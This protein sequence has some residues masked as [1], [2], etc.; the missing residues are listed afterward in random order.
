MCEARRKQRRFD[1]RQRKK[2]RVDISAFTSEDNRF[3]WNPADHYYDDMSKALISFQNKKFKN[4]EPVIQL[5]SKED[6][7]N[8]TIL[9]IDICDEFLNASSDSDS[10]AEQSTTHTNNFDESPKQATCQYKKSKRLNDL[11]SNEET[12]DTI[13]MSDGDCMELSHTHDDD[14]TVGTND[15]MVSTTKMT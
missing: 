14:S 9:D 6:L 2:P 15:T 10:S 5:S 1:L 12:A 11:F 7:T 13:S 3:E 8:A 4:N